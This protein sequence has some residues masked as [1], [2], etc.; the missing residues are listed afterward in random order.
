M[1][2]GNTFPYTVDSWKADIQLAH[3]AGIDGF[4]LNL[5]TDDWQTGHVGDA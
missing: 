1:M 4:A 5:G 2:M 3:S